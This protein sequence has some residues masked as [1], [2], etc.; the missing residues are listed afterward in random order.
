MQWKNDAT[1]KP[2]VLQMAIER[3]QFLYYYYLEWFILDT[4]VRITLT[5]IN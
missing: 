2:P 1:I 3:W 5:Q 4:A